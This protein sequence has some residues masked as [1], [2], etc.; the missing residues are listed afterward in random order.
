MAGNL[1]SVIDCVLFCTLLTA[2]CKA[3][4]SNRT[5]GTE[6]WFSDHEVVTVFMRVN[7]NFLQNKQPAT[8]IHFSV[9]DE[10]FSSR[11]NMIQTMPQYLDR[12][13]LITVNDNFHIPMS[14]FTEGIRFY[15]GF[16]TS[17]LCNYSTHMKVT[18]EGLDGILICGKKYFYLE[19]IARYIPNHSQSFRYNTKRM[20]LDLQFRCIFYKSTD[21]RMRFN[22]LNILWEGLI[23]VTPSNVDSGETK[24]S[25]RVKRSGETRTSSQT[26]CT[27]HVVADHMFYQTTGQSDILTTISEITYIILQANLIFRGTDFDG[28]E[29]GDN[30]GFYTSK[31]S[32]YTEPD[33][34]KMADAASVELYLEKLS[35][36]DFSD[37]CLAT[38]FTSRN[39]AKGVIGLA[40]VGSSSKH[41]SSGGICQHRILYKSKR[42]CLNTNLITNINNEK[43]IPSYLA[44]LTLAHE[45][46]HS[47]GSPHDDIK[48]EDCAPAGNYGNYLMYPYASEGGKPNNNI[49]SLC[50]INYMYPV[51]RN[52]GTCLKESV[53][54]FCG[55]GFREAYEECDCGTT[56]TCAA[57]DPCCTPSD[58]SYTDP[59]HPCT[60]R[61]SQGSRCSP[62]LSHC[63]TDDC[64]VVTAAVNKVCKAKSECTEQSICDGI[65]RECP[66]EVTIPDTTPCAGGSKSCKSGV[67][68]GSACATIGLKPCTC[69]DK[70]ACFICCLNNL[71]ECF[72]YE[73]DKN[74]NLALSSGTSCNAKQGFCNGEGKCI[75]VDETSTMDRLKKVFTNDDADSVKI[76]FK[77]Q[78]YYIVLAAAAFA[79]LI[80]IFVRTCR[81]DRYIQTS[82]YMYGRLAGIQREAE[83][84]KA[85]L[86]RRRKESK[87][88]YMRK[89]DKT[90]NFSVEID[91]PT[92]VARM[93]VFFPTTP[94][95][96]ILK[97]LKSSANEE[98]AVRWLLLKNYPFRRFC[99]N[100]TTN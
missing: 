67:C 81:G 13:L 62:K 30:I 10:N 8:E 59:D 32:I 6:T 73:N 49:F 14:N 99:K 54:S 74:E 80:F 21:V 100:I 3:Y 94:L 92:A 42:M 79:C 35:E 1:K 89:I 11:S 64:K 51:I 38:A 29:S 28:D 78:W 63:C 85:Y 60:F 55:N 75:S 95:D 98:S 72:P 97:T 50:S 56:A 43:R 36:Y 23:N 5:I 22:G 47:F 45:M 18:S 44:A 58:I 61:R 70:N 25:G 9:T 66:A 34:Y 40:W 68:V 53:V 46:G 83:I 7:E 24:S 77:D 93:M 41:G 15:K 27:L 88:R 2:V 87:E 82:A 26:E 84:Q 12:N 65:S 57:V 37:Y 69:T 17:R 52:K 16:M 31:V 4:N 48:S 96:V 20:G 71:S 90:E 91:F 33:S 76:W 19:P 86:Q 39:F